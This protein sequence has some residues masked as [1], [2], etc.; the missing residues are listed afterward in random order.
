MSKAD[1]VRVG[2]IQP[3]LEGT[4][5]QNVAKVEALVREAARKGAQIVLVPELYE[6]PYFCKTESE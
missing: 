2:I 3:K 5:S 1:K 6:G 4:R